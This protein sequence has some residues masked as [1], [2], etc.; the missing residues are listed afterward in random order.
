M[1]AS[2]QRATAVKIDQVLFG[3]PRSADIS[4]G[5][6]KIISIAADKAHGQILNNLT[7]DFISMK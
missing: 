6:D 2:E 1:K 4:Q 5:S 3:R 7:S